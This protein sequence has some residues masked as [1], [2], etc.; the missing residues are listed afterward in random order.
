M[1]TPYVRF[2][3]SGG[4]P[5]VQLDATAQNPL[6]TVYAPPIATNVAT[7]TKGYGSQPLLRYVQYNSTSNPAPVAWPA[8][9]YWLD[10]TY[11]AVTSVQTEAL[12]GAGATAGLNSIAGYLLINTTNYGSTLTATLLNTGYVWIQTGGFLAGAA[13]AAS[14]AIGDAVIGIT[15]ANWV[16]G[17]TAEGTAPPVRP[18]GWALT[19]VASSVADIWLDCDYI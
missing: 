4:N 5:N 1:F 2:G 8:P 7:T 16:P 6:G 11:T 9:V 15:G 14:T 10:E 17:R 3:T 19:A 12:G 13:V 18:F